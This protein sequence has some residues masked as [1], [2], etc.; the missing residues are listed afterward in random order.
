MNYWKVTLYRRDSETPVI[1]DLVKHA[2]WEESAR[3]IIAQFKVG[4]EHEHHYW[5]W[6]V[7]LISHIKIERGG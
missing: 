1:Y 4:S 2:W 3:F 5:T 6:P 7:D